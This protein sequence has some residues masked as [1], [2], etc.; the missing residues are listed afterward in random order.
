MNNTH[1]CRYVM[2]QHTKAIIRNLVPE[3]LSVLEISGINWR[4]LGFKKYRSIQY[5]EFDVCTAVLSEEFDLIVAEQV[6]EHI[7]FPLRAATN[8]LRMLRQGGTFLLTTPFLIHYHPTPLDLWRWTAHGLNCFLLDAG[9]VG[10]RTFS[11]GNKQCV[12]A[13]FGSWVDFDPQLHSLENDPL[14]PIVVWGTG[15]KP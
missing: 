2:N 3:S 9:F 12:I 11:W 5:P 14:Y 10:V 6:F 1:W 4:D 15:Q 8:V 13:N 7:R